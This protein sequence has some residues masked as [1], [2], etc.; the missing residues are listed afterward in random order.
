M[1]T[2]MPVTFLD[3]LQAVAEPWG[4]NCWLTIC[5]PSFNRRFQKNR[6]LLRSLHQEVRGFLSN[7]YRRID[8]R[9]VV[10]AFVTAVQEKGALPYEGYVTDT[11]IAIQA[12][13]PDVYE[14]VPGEVVA[15]E[16]SLENSDFGNGALSVRAHLLRIWCTNLAVTQ[17]EM[18]QVHL[19]SVRTSP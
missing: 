8:S 1:T 6:Y 9:P 5:K 11:K 3:S 7:S 13:M 19:G 2:D 10:E 17:E 15:Y 12:I 18:R 16:L 14:P 4:L